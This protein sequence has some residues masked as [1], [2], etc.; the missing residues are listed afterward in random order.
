MVSPSNLDGSDVNPRDI[1]ALDFGSTLFGK[2]QSLPLTLTNGGDVPLNL[3]PPEYPVTPGL[4]SVEFAS[5]TPDPCSRRT[6]S[7]GASCQFVVFFSPRGYDGERSGELTITDATSNTKWYVSLRGTAEALPLQPTSAPKD[8]AQWQDPAVCKG[9][10]PTPTEFGD[11]LHELHGKYVPTIFQVAEL[12]LYLIKKEVGYVLTKFVAHVATDILGW[13]SVQE[14]PAQLVGQVVESHVASQDFV[15]LTDHTYHQ[16]SDFDQFVYP[17]QGYRGLLAPGNARVEGDF[18]QSEAGRMTVESETFNPLDPAYPGLP[19]WVWPTTGD[20]IKVVGQHIL[21]CGHSVSSPRGKL[22]RSEIHPVQFIATY[23][24]AAL[25][26][27]ASTG[28]VGSYDPHSGGRAT[29]VDV[30]ATS[31]G[32]PAYGIGT[33]QRGLIWQPNAG[34]YTFD[35]VAPPQP[36]PTATLAPPVVEPRCP[37]SWT[38]A[39][40]RPNE[41]PSLTWIPLANSRGYRFTLTLSRAIHPFE[42]GTI[43]VEWSD[44]A[45]PNAVTAKTRTYVVT[46]RSLKVLKVPTDLSNRKWSLYASINEDQTGSLLVP[47]SGRPGGHNV[48]R[49]TYID[50]TKGERITYLRDRPFRVTV[51]EGQ[52][53]HIEFRANAWVKG[54][55]FE[56]HHI[57]FGQSLPDFGDDHFLGTSGQQLDARDLGQLTFTAPPPTEGSDVLPNHVGTDELYS[58]CSQVACYQINY[59]IER[60]SP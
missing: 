39:S 24:D 3:S 43:W 55:H 41:K 45:R 36:T 51:V 52:G 19:S 10:G 35:A 31:Y 15:G 53:L 40:C 54:L 46:I 16:N 18:T 33:R 38:P 27:G 49:Q 37:P 8:Q 23:R 20:K 50:V 30:Y 2:D 56:G 25:T 12:P 22:Y 29:R 28:G 17:D 7:P 48:L 9:R 34:P 6:L 32:G 58:G 11:L 44:P 5:G 14:R 59:T 1:G 47:G 26:P 21:D 60:T 42:G 57:T 4:G 13:A